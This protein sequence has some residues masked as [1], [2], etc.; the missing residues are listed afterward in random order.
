M[1]EVLLVT[2]MSGAGR[3]TVSAALED[4]GWF[5]IDNLPLELVVRVGELTSAGDNDYPG[6]AFIVGRSGGVSP[7]TLLA[8]ERE[9]QQRHQ[10]VKILFLDAPDEVLILR[11]EGNR[12]RHPFTGATLA[13]SIGGERDLL[14]PIRDAADLVIDTGSINANQLRRRIAETFTDASSTE[15]LRVSLVSFGYTYGIPR[16][17][18]LVFDC[19]FLPNPYWIEELRPLTGLD[20]EVSR[21]VLDQEPAQHFL[22]DVVAL[23]AWQIPAFAQEGKSYL[24]IAIGCTGGRHRSVAVAEEIRRRL[25]IEPAVFHRDI[26]R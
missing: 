26:A 13:E 14:A 20:Q 18:D 11:F 9:L 12:R 2:G 17:V 15:S 19:R 16:D 1:S 22:H 8:V 7:E 23:L 5:V 10:S 24:S 3:S 25:G 4:L 6:V 21:Y